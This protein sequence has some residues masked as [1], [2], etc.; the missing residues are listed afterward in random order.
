[1]VWE[2]PTFQFCEGGFAR[3]YLPNRHYDGNLWSAFNNLSTGRNPDGIRK[4][5]DTWYAILEQYATR[6]LSY[7]TDRLPA[8]SSLAKEFGK[9]KGD[10]AY[11]AGL[12]RSDIIRGLLWSAVYTRQEKRGLSGT[13]PTER[14][15][16]AVYTAPSWSWA[17]LDPWPLEIKD[18]GFSR[19]VP[20]SSKEGT[21]TAKVLNVTTQK[22]TSDPFGKV[23]GGTITLEAPFCYIAERGEKDKGEK[24]V[25]GV[26]KWI[27][28]SFNIEYTSKQWLD[29]YLVQHVGYP[30]QHFAAIILQ[31][32]EVSSSR[33]FLFLESVQR[34]GENEIQLYRRIGQVTQYNR[35][36]SAGGN[37]V[38]SRGNWDLAWKEV[39]II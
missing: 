38:I 2:C 33:D 25:S 21:F 29:E 39:T 15:L 8:V 10:D 14:N 1:M 7:S 37:K 5:L 24:K 26:E 11:C 13:S 23:T 17:S 3:H 20:E 22:S 32:S 19:Q 16:N 9:L 6:D 28:R 27:A 12:W 18:A 4:V 31:E 35:D 34:A 30:G 36:Y